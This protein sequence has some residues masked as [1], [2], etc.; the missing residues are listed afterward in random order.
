MLKSSFKLSWITRA[1]MVVASIAML[2][3]LIT[4][5]WRFDFFAPQYPDGLW[6]HIWHNRLEGDVKVINGLNHYIGMRELDQ[7]TFPEFGYIRYLV[8][9]LSVMGIVPVI[10]GRRRWLNVWALVLVGVALLGLY[11]FWSWEY[12]YGHNLDPHAPIVNPGM[13][14]QPPLIGYK[15]LLNFEIYSQPWHGGYALILGI[16][17]VVL[18]AFVEWMRFRKHKRKLT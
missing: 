10:T 5:L 15:L 11:D 16:S 14:Y 18:M 17:L 6:L 12:D 9:A 7:S 4:P 13:V 2:G 1:L 8:I 3:A